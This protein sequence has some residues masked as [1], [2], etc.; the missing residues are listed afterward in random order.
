MPSRLVSAAKGASRGNLRIGDHWNAITIIALSQSNPLKAVAE[1]VENSIDARAKTIV[2]TRG[3]EK[4]QHYLRVKDDGEGV[5]RNAD[6]DPDFHYVATHVCD[7]IK[8]R[9]KTQG[10]PGLQGEFGIGLLS[11]WTLGEDL[12]LTSAG[13]GRAWQMHLRKGDP[14]YRI[15]QRATLF[16]EPGTEVLIRGILPGIKNFSGEKI[17]WYL[18]SELR[19]RIRHTGVSIRVVDRTAR[20]EFKVEPRKFEGRLLHELEGTLPVQSE[21]YAELYLHAHS[22]ANAVSL[23]RSG[24]RVLENIAELEAFARM[25][26]TSGYVQGIIDAPLLNLTPGTRLGVIHDAVLAGLVDEL[27][28]LE[29]RLAKIIDDQ[30]RAEEERASRDVLRSVQGALKEALLALPAEEYD[31]FDLHR[32]EGKRRPRT[33]TEATPGDAPA[34]PEEQTISMQTAESADESGPQ[35]QF[36]EYAGPLFSVVISPTSSVVEVGGSRAL[37]ALARD[38]ARRLVDQNLTFAWSVIEGEGT[39][40]PMDGEIATFH[41]GSEPGLTRIEVVVTQADI[42][43]RADAQITVS[44]SLLNKAGSGDTNYQGLP[45]YT[46]H[47]AAGELWRSRFDAERNLVVINNGHRDFVYAARNKMLKLRYI[48]RLFAKELVLKNFVGIAQD[49]LLERL[50]E[51]TLYTEENLR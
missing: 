25:P 24:T 37:R 18:A 1:L 30:Q 21:V 31:W 34:N 42:V 6:G 26:W 35:R 41:A 27:A 16:P 43:C 32:G 9:L 11:F 45:G 29:G 7:S 47:K 4:G 28:P 17:Q 40:E 23:Y 48:C 38:R 3:K 20:S 36:F 33:H 12:L 15:T 14:S 51:L 2:I 22:P 49:Q 46:Y 19:D 50:L 13:D 8:R 44:A 5:R 10:R 39:L